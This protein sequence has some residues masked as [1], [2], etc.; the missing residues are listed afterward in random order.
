[1]FGFY[2]HKRVPATVVTDATFTTAINVQGANRVAFEIPTFAAGLSTASANVYVNVCNSA[3]GTFRRL[4]DVGIYSASSGI[5][6]WEVPNG[7]GDYTVLCRP[8]VGFDWIKL[9]VGTGGS[10]VTAT[11]GLDCFVHVMK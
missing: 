6:V 2:G 9:E 3:T 8:A 5:Q 1:M 7:A 11:A 10:S 4:K